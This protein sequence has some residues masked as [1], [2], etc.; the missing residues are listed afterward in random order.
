MGLNLAISRIIFSSVEKQRS[1]LI[2]ASLLKQIAGR[3]GRSSTDGF[4][5][6]FYEKDLEYIKKC[7]GGNSLEKGETPTD[8]EAPEEILDEN[9]QFTEN[10][11]FI[12]RA[13][14][15]P[16]IDDVLKIAGKLEEEYQMLNNNKVSIYDVFLQFDL[17]SNSNEMYFIKDLKKTMKIAYVLKDIDS[18]ISHQYGF[19]MAPCK[20]KE[21][22][23][24]M[25]RK[26]FIEFDGGNGEVLIPESLYI[27]KYSYSNRN[28]SLDEIMLLQD[29]NNCKEILFF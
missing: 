8:F 28:V 7:I 25:L 1:G 21:Y 11:K 6:A 17:H 18:S 3:A 9:Y 20:T 24:D 14:L 19:V 10:Q 22:C 23:L 2:D 15:F 12:K 16:A 26:F 29:K 27:D 4:V 13:C 5:T